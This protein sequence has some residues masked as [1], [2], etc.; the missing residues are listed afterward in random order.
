MLTA[1]QLLAPT[2]TSP[3]LKSELVYVNRVEKV[4][5]AGVQAVLIETL[6]VAG[7]GM[8]EV[9]LGVVVVIDND[10][11]VFPVIGPPMFEF[12]DEFARA[13]VGA[14]VFNVVD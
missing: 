4:L 14:A 12:T 9:V 5:P 8:C 6:V 2:T 11:D 13:E 7:S 1:S 3:E 10:V